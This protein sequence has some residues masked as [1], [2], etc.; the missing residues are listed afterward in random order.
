MNRPTH[1]RDLRPSLL[2]L[3]V[4]A[5]CSA[6]TAQTSTVDA[7]VSV[8]VGALVDGDRGERALFGQYNGLRTRNAVGLLDIE[9]DRRYEGTGA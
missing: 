6:V 2:A 7:S 9:Y 1:S 3:A 5:A 4:L 8:G